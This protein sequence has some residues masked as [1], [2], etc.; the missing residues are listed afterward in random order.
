M[1][2]N[3]PVSCWILIERLA[4]TLIAR[5]SERG[6]EN[7]KKWRWRLSHLHVSQESSKRRDACDLS[8]NLLG[9]ASRFP[10]CAAHSL[11]LNHVS[12]DSERPS[13]PPL[14]SHTDTPIPSLFFTLFFPLLGLHLEC[15][16]AS[17][18]EGVNNYSNGRRCAPSFICCLACFLLTVS[19][20][21]QRR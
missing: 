7:R 15:Q 4:N 6:S 20:D 14:T 9:S 11:S 17:G 18:P 16:S 2:S 13:R 5:E 8:A 12:R 19:T 21:I 10:V 3:Q 1:S